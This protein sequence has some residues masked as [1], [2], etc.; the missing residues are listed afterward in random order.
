MNFAAPRAL[1]EMYKR[2]ALASTDHRTLAREWFIESAM[3][4]D[5][6]AAASDESSFI[7]DWRLS[8][9][10]DAARAAVEERRQIS[11]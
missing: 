4:A 9:R 5:R 7:A 1:A 3:A 8:L 10:L 2:R 6:A 11:A